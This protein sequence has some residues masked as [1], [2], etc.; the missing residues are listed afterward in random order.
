MQDH[1]FIS[2]GAVLCRI[3][4]RLCNLNLLWGFNIAVS[5]I[6]WSF[7]CVCCICFSQPPLPYLCVGYRRWEFF[8]CSFPIVFIPR[9]C[10]GFAC[11]TGFPPW[12][13]LVFHSFSGWCLTFHSFP[14]NSGTARYPSLRKCFASWPILINPEWE[15]AHRCLVLFCFHVHSCPAWRQSDL[16]LLPFSIIQ[17]CLAMSIS[18]ATRALCT[19]LYPALGSISF[20]CWRFSNKQWLILSKWFS[21]GS[22]LCCV[23]NQWDLNL[24]GYPWSF[25]GVDEESRNRFLQWIHSPPP[26]FAHP[27]LGYTVWKCSK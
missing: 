24:Y 3:Y 8:C 25:T 15:S 13:P 4:D 17:A 7:I 1:T 21:F 20:A 19:G 5:M 22:G 12:F 2:T 27:Y 14:P 26:I 18:V 16:L 10:C 9:F 11:P 23:V 6:W